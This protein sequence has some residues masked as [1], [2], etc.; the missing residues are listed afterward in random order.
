MKHDLYFW[1]LL[2]KAKMDL[3]TSV[4]IEVDEAGKKYPKDQLKKFILQNL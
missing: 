1:D 2:L 3:K 4:A